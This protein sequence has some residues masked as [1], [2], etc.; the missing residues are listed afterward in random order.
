MNTL[1]K[2][3]FVTSL[4]ALAVCVTVQAQKK[5]ATFGFVD[6]FNGKDLSGWIAPDGDHTWQVLEGRVLD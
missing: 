4:A 2:H 5:E 6:L 3:L 1:S